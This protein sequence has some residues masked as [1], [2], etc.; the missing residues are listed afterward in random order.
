M[1]IALIDPNQNLWVSGKF[2]RN[3]QLEPLSLEYIASVMAEAGYTVKL[4][5]QDDDDNEELIKKVLGFEPEVIGFSTFT[6]NFNV[7]CEIAGR[8]KKKMPSATI[9]F[10]GHHITGCPEGIINQPIDFGVYGEGEYS[11][12]QLVKAIE[13]NKNPSKI[14]GIIINNNGSIHKT[15][16][17]ERIIELDKLPFPLRSKKVLAKCKKNSAVFPPPSQQVSVAQIITSRGCKNNCRY[18]SSSKMW[19]SKVIYRNP[20]SVVDEI[21]YLHREFGTNLIHLSDLSVNQNRDHLLKF[22]RCLIKRNLNVYW[23]SSGNIDLVDEEV[24]KTMFKASCTRIGFGIENLLPKTIE[25]IKPKQNINIAE[26]QNTLEM[27]RKNGILIKGFFMI[28]YPWETMEDLEKMSVDICKLP[29]DEIRITIFTPFP[30]T[31]LYDEF[32][33]QDLIKSTDFS[34][35]SVEK[36]ILNYK[37]FSDT[38]LLEMRAKIFKRFYLGAEY[39]NRR[40]KQSKKFPEY[41]LSYDELFNYLE[42]K[43]AFA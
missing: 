13:F 37:W 40:K 39:N 21:E 12:L 22:C 14:K 3:S 28:G 19:S 25:K 10:G 27:V 24:I 26:L 7:A 6:Y 34:D 1:K 33:K 18:C 11:F 23:T 35:Y 41:S 2:C 31:K 5:H 32:L 43:G 8:I 20:E 29:L 9:V 42:E 30:G 16:P 38:E 36:P 4:F 15:P 17:R